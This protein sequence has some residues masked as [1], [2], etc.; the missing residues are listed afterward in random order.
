MSSI[1]AALLSSQAFAG[2]EILGSDLSGETVIDSGATAI[3]ESGATA[4]LGSG[5]IIYNYGTLKVEGTLNGKPGSKIIS[6][7]GFEE[8]ADST[9]AKAA[10]PFGEDKTYMEP[11]DGGQI[12]EGGKISDDI[13][14]ETGNV[15]PAGALEGTDSGHVFVLVGGEVAG[16]FKLQGNEEI[17]LE[18][19]E[20]FANRTDGSFTGIEHGLDIVRKV[21][22]SGDNSNFVRDNSNFVQGN[23]TIGAEGEETEVEIAGNEALPQVDI[24]VQNATLTINTDNA[25]LGGDMTIGGSTG[26]Y[27]HGQ[28]TPNFHYKETVTGGPSKLSVPSGAKLVIKPG[29]TLTFSGTTWTPIG[30]AVTA[31]YDTPDTMEYDVSG[32]AAKFVDCFKETSTGSGT[33]SDGIFTYTKSDSTYTRTKQ[34]KV[35][36]KE[37]SSECYVKSD[38]N[39]GLEFTI[40]WDNSWFISE[41]GSLYLD[42]NMGQPLDSGSELND[43]SIVYYDVR[44][45]N[46][47]VFSSD[48]VTEGHDEESYY[49]DEQA[50][51][52]AGG[53]WGGSGWS[54]R[55]FNTVDELISIINGINKDS[56]SWIKIGG[57][58]ATS[59]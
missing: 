50:V 16:N 51:K 40:G 24:T 56:G 33:Y 36:G 38:D 12:T 26:T 28:Y 19:D 41:Y 1:I 37:A 58:Y 27:T 13:A 2:Q 6:G 15:I 46:I 22:L 44:E 18:V 5:G 53:N 29:Q 10:N 17:A 48:V 43:S 54:S 23:M 31:P 49:V 14:R 25:K 20:N 32:A 39:V 55:A 11:G 35:V 45:R 47:Y 57:L 21:K 7:V 4:D 8:M 30:P 3:V 34:M 59:L 52:N 9:A 42:A